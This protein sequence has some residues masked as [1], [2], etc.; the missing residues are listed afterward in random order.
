[1][2]NILELAKRYKNFMVFAGV[3]LLS[4]VGYRLVV[5]V[6]SSSDSPDQIQTVAVKPIIEDASV[7][8]EFVETLLKLNTIKIKREDGVEDEDNVFKKK[9]YQ[10]LQDR[11]IVIRSDQVERRRNNPFTIPPS[12]TESAGGS[13]FQ[14]TGGAGGLQQI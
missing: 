10:D 8:K 4:F 11:R 5:G 14:S 13:G 2:A 6:F 12:Q 3:F 1:M 7:G 9:L